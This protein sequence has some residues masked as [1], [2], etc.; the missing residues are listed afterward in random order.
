M[1]GE[2]CGVQQAGV[3]VENVRTVGVEQINPSRRRNVLQAG[4]G[5]IKV[6]SPVFVIP[7]PLSNICDHGRKNCGIA[8]QKAATWIPAMLSDFT[9]NGRG[10]SGKR[11]HMVVSDVLN[12]NY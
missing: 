12:V 3:S 4:G 10:G 1:R 11:S 6:G 7:S 8:M 5:G 9:T 2:L